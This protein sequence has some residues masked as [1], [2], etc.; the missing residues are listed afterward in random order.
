MIFHIFLHL[1]GLDICFE[2]TS[3]TRRYY[4]LF[5]QKE[6]PL[7]ISKR[8][9]TTFCK[10]NSLG[11][12]L[13]LSLRLVINKRIRIRNDKFFSDGPFF[14]SETNI[15]ANKFHARATFWPSF[16]AGWAFLPFDSGVKTPI[17]VKFFTL[18]ADPKL[19]SPNVQIHSLWDFVAAQLWLERFLF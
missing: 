10:I 12:T 14:F 15:G 5:R 9:E 17:G 16:S 19:L 1:R 7:F 6:S 18:Q 8:I 13:N 4:F 11:N 2:S 3:N